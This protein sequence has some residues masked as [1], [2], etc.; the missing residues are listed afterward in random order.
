MKSEVGF[1]GCLWFHYLWYDFCACLGA[2]K[3]RDSL[4]RTL[5]VVVFSAFSF[6][7]SFFFVVFCFVLF[8]CLCICVFVNKSNIST[9][10][11]YEDTIPLWHVGHRHITE[12]GVPKDSRWH[13]ANVAVFISD[14][15]QPSL[16]TSFRSFLASVS[17]FLALSTVFHSINSPTNSPLSHSVLPVLFLPYWSFQLYI[18][19]KKSIPEPWCNP[20]W[21]TGLKAPT[22]QPTNLGYTLSVFLS[23]KLSYLVKEHSPLQAQLSVIYCFIVMASDT[24]NLLLLLKQ[25]S[26][27]ISS[28]LLTNLRYLLLM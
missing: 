21:L 25:L 11:V 23:S 16:P 6:F 10:G 28:D 22:N 1:W 5:H 7:L 15:N 13:G 18:S 8:F 24:S 3:C 9:C 27:S 12:S 14:I 4:E 19:L 20:L 17:V 2:G 26:K